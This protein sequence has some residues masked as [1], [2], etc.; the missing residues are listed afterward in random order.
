[1]LRHPAQPSRRLLRAG[2]AALTLF[3][4]VISTLLTAAPA[5]AHGENT[6]QA[7]IRL[8]TALFYDV[9]FSTTELAVGEELVITGKVRIMESWPQHTVAPPET[10]YLTVATPGPVFLAEERRI[11]GQLVPQS[12]RIEKGETYPFE[13]RLQA[14]KPGNWHVHPALAAEGTGMLLGQGE[15]I[16]VTPGGPVSNDLTLLSGEKVDLNTFG[17]GSVVTWH[18]VGVAFGVA[19]LLYWIRRPLLTRFVEVTEGRGRA[20][21]SRRDQ[22]LGVG[23]AVGVLA[24][25]V[26]GNAYI[27]TKAPNTVP[28]QVARVEAVPEPKS[29]LESTL[30]VEVLAAS[31]AP[32]PTPTLRL[33]VKATNSG[34]TTARLSQ[35]QL[36]ETTVRE[37]PTGATEDF[38]FE[39]EPD[40]EIPPGTTE[41]FEVVVAGAYLEDKNLI[42][43][44]EAQIRI[45]GLLFF[46]DPTG[47]RSEVE[48]NEL[49]SAIR[50]DFEGDGGR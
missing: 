4:S 23:L 21:I 20:L 8:S 35:I 2:A 11:S 28:L 3:L 43:L 17:L 34:E 42:P 29:K 39:T 41:T 22:I 46:V 50:P 48:V 37:E 5:Q 26:I 6:Q 40:N 19:W 30:A 31:Y 33:R 36:G 18:L 15:Y 24:A 25:G 38:V 9:E 32:A 49:T 27:N 45:T 16:K 12:V 13:I 14:R 1:M 44:D 10:A 7:F 47:Q